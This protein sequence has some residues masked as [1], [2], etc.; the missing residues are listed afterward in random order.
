[1]R[2]W[3]GPFYVTGVFWY[4]LPHWAVRQGVLSVATFPF[5]VMLFTT[6]FALFLRNVRK[7]IAANLEVVLGPC[8]FWERQRRIYRTLEA[9]AWCYGARYEH[10]E[11]PE[12]FHVEVEGTENIPDDPG[13][14]LLFVTAHLGQWELS[15]HLASH[16]RRRPVHV[17]REEE[18][19]P[20]SQRYV[21]GLLRDLSADGVTTH[22]A[23]DDP[24][25][26][27][28]LAEALRRGE[29]VALQGDRPRAHGRTCTA[30]I[31]GRPMPL[32]VGPQALARAT[33]AALLPV[34]SFREGRRTYRVIVRPAINV[35]RTGQRDADVA[36]AV[37]ALADEIEWAIRRAP[38]QWFCFRPLWD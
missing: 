23:S 19:D 4:R 8:G 36:A 31:F 28:A 13:R 21:E 35:A 37:Q 16:G 25:L 34:F 27:L 32:P 5:F 24:R 26:G 6:F 10:H 38:L 12:L 17:V 22:F 1:V 9:F 15:S 11:H 2:R 18:L 7:G 30:R 29:I 33:G 14:G 20:E 3:L